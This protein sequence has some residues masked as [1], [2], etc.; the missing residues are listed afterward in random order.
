MT[1]DRDAII[2]AAFR[3]HVSDVYRLAFSVVRNQQAAE[4]V[5]QDT[6]IR[7]YDRFGKFDTARPI[8]PWLHA[9]ATNIAIDHVRRSRVRRWIGLAGP[10]E[11]SLEDSAL[12]DESSLVVERDAVAELL[13]ELPARSRAMLVLRH[14]YGYDDRSIAELVG[15]SP[16]NVRT[17]ISRAHQRLR[18]ILASPAAHAGENGRPIDGDW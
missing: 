4:D 8:G 11:I 9:I 14:A 5:T 10:R 17:Q 12:P 7:A 13:D 1:A 2:D 15:T 3:A 18:L 16:G 6:F